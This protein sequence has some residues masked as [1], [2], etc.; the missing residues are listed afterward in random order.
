[1]AIVAERLELINSFHKTKYAVE[2][3]NLFDERE[4]TGTR[5]KIDI[6]SRIT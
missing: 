6:P 5:V 3:A 4:E 2:V 1:M